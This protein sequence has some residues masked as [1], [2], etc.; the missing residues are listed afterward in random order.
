MAGS[1]KGIVVE[2]GGDT[3]GL[4]NALK[5]VNSSTSSLSREL[6]GV[7][8]LL[9]LDPKN[10][11]LVA[12]KQQIL[13][14]NIEQTSEKIEELRKAQ[15]MAD[16]TIAEGGEISQENYRNLQREIINTENKLKELKVEAS[17]WTKAGRSIEEF[18]NK[19][20]NISSKLDKMGTTLTTRLTLPI[21]GVAVALVKEAKEFETAFTG[22]EKTVDG[23]VT[24]MEKLKQGI[25][26]MA[27][28][29]PASTTEIAS[30]AEAAGQLGI[31]TDNVLDFTKTMINMGNAT[32]LSADEA[33][34]TLARFANVTKMSQSDF[35]KLGSVIVALGNNFATTEAE[36]SEMGMNLAS[37]GKQVGMSQAEIMALATALSSV[38]LE[39]EAGGTAF[40]K[41][42]VNMQLAVEKGG[43]D[44]KDFASVAGM[45]TENFKKAFSENATNA[46]MKF[47]EGLS[48]SGERGQSAIKVLD[49]MG[50]TETRL[51]DALLR[52]ANA[53]DVM[54]DA[55]EL[56]NKAWDENS[57]LTNEASK[58]YQT[59]DS[60]MQMTSNKIK[61]AATLA[62]D[63][64]T[65]TFNKLLDKVDGLVDKFNDLN[66]EEITNI[67]K[68]AGLV[69]AIGPAVKIVG[70]FGSSIGKTVKTVGNLSQAIALTG[71]TTTEAFK[72]ASAG[73]QSLAKGLTFLTSP[74]GLATA[75]ITLTA[76][77]LIYFATKETEAQKKAKEFAEEMSN[78]RQSLEEYNKG[79]DDTTNAN[80]SHIESVKKLKDELVTLVD[81]NGKVK[82]GY[83]SRVD[84]ILNEL[85]NALGTEYKLNG[86]VIDSYKNLQSEIDETIEKKKAEIKLSSEEEKYKNAIEKQQEAVENLKKAQEEYQS[87]AKQFFEEHFG[88]GTSYDQAFEK[89]KK[90][91][92]D[93]GYTAEASA[94]YAKEW[95]DYNGGN[96]KKACEDAEWQV[97]E[98]TN[99]VKNYEEDYAKFT[100]GKYAEIGNAIKV[101]TEDWTKK[102][103]EE[104][105]KSIG[106]QGNAMQ[107]YKQIYEN[108]GSQIALQL[109]QQA[110]QN[111]DNLT[112]EL[113]KRTQTLEELGPEEV[114]AWKKIA[115]ESYSSYSEEI[116]KMPPE[117][118]QKIQDATGVIAGG[119][120]QM[121]EKA[122]ELGRKTVEEFDKSADAKGKA[123]NTITGY[124]N[125]LS[126]NDKRELL[127]Q[128]GI[129]NVD[130][131]LD[132]LNKGNLS[133]ENGRNILKGLWNGLKDG[134]WQGK[135]LGAASGLAKAVNKAFT[136]KD[137][138]D[139]HSP[140]KK[141]KKF[142]EYYVQP[143][144]D[145]MNARKNSIISTARNLATEVNRAFENNTNIPQIQDFG[146]LQGNISSR[147]IDST[148]TVFT[149]PQIVFN[150]QELDEAKLQQCFNYVNRKFGSQY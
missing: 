148:K 48:K 112:Q 142:A 23:T 104:I 14:E 78:S 99:D 32:N 100:E 50:I 114:E 1:I 43:D 125:G 103:L 116:A 140:S 120:P 106:E 66:E 62:G 25:K 45:T 98:Y 71:K 113:A 24:Q 90:G 44:L 27:E 137:G 84:F 17:N 146:K 63:K 135:I 123:L 76:G 9:K 74:A 79:I 58:R 105:N 121:Q 47:V 5:K 129:E 10:T 26:N 28:E 93:A 36:I 145:V 41:V 110:Q 31:Q 141:M 51:R 108:T 80:L 77:A 81:E 97:K 20:N 91:Y 33:A 2:I 68:T 12:Q 102:S 73:T 94:K 42:M 53:S 126:D 82:E 19:I 59:L 75:A 34:T 132:E 83:K 127:K 101:S 67:L 49:D 69:A 40:S 134:T 4:Q 147:I 86:D 107:Q 18:G 138:W 130:I 124:L 150:V 13:K 56:G 65:P 118:Q 46:I 149:T 117:M 39:A 6:K 61:N 139:E 52:S 7:N 64:L 3:S 60:R 119:T 122:E 143:I 54:S 30:V 128:A 11:E 87:N 38:G 85:N 21:A 96:L 29:I 109:S 15:E 8:S 92:I 144:S 131:V 22:V 70:T 35:E 133:E 72:N 115:S 55:I 88:E 37:A 89:L 136:G 95:M 57:A 16:R 111:L